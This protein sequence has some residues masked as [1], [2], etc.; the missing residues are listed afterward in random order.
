MNRWAALNRPPPRTEKHLKLASFK[1]QLTVEGLFAGR[2]R[3]SFVNA[4][5]IQHPR[6]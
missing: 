3:H 5:G 4:I 2:E 6:F 1:L